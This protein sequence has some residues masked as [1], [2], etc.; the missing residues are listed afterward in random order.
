M[1]GF[2]NTGSSSLD[3]SASRAAASSLHND[4]FSGQQQSVPSP[5]S[6]AGQSQSAH[7]PN[8]ELTQSEHP[9]HWYDGI[10]TVA[11]GVADEVIHH[12]LHV[13]ESAAIGVGVGAA[14]L[15]VAAVAPEVATVAAIG[16]AF[17][18]GVELL[19]NAPK[20]GFEAAVV[21]DPDHHSA[22]EVAAA[23]K[24]LDSLGHVSIDNLVTA[25]TGGLTY[26]IGNSVL[27]GLAGDGVA[28]AT[29]SATSATAETVSSSAVTGDGT[30][31]LPAPETPAALAA[32]EAQPLLPAPEGAPPVEPPAASVDTA[33]APADVQPAANAAEAVE[34][35]VQPVPVAE[36]MQGKPAALYDRI[37]VNGS[38]SGP[39]QVQRIDSPVVL[40]T[41]AGRTIY[42]GPGDVLVT[43]ADG[44]QAIVNEAQFAEH[45]SPVRLEVPN[46]LLTYRKTLPITA[47][48]SSEPFTWT[49]NGE[50]MQA[51]AGDWRVTQPNGKISSVTP[52]IFART[53]EA[54]PNLGPN[55]FLKTALTH[56][57]VLDR[58]VTVT[59]LEGAKTAQAGD[60]LV[61]GPAGE[62]YPVPRAEFE[63]MYAQVPS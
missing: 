19:V 2:E 55:S 52:D 56:A 63:H 20:W 23:H 1:A 48:Q 34:A 17:I 62:Q 57:Q 21:A 16:G 39:V 22:S 25:V 12:P 11:E 29:G 53:Y 26:G 3:A 24:D 46:P 9:H 4:A 40:T 59:T 43:R 36:A 5:N 38:N 31:A 35:P 30:L 37:G 18:G 6:D 27:S 33:V 44:A 49:S 15:A 7:L 32:P 41:E 13:L 61:T 47:E 14:A 10:V 42:G 60:Y 28:A 8:V 45:Y 51:N 54:A 58:D 50:T